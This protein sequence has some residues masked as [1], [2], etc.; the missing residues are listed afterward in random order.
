MTD[1]VTLG[2]LCPQCGRVHAPQVEICDCGV[3]TNRGIM[4]VSTSTETVS[5]PPVWALDGQ[6]YLYAP[7]GC[8]MARL[9]G[10]GV[11]WLW[12][13]R[14]KAELPLTTETLWA[15]HISYTARGSHERGNDA[16]NL[17]D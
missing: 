15:L 11:L 16:R 10:A 14:S 4:S 5:P 12:D 17:H 13:K 3:L 7:S 2:W 6:G 1:H 9:D 8:K